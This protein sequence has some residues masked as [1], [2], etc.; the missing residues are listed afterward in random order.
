MLAMLPVLP[1]LHTEFLS[2]ASLLR[3][4]NYY[5]KTICFFLFV[6]YVSLKISRDLHNFIFFIS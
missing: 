2:S 1:V 4:E 3:V 6:R 5:L